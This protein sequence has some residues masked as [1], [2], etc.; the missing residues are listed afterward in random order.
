MELFKLHPFDC[1]NTT[2]QEYFIYNVSGRYVRLASSNL[3]SLS[4][5]HTKS[6][7][8]ILRVFPTGNDLTKTLPILHR[9]RRPLPI[10]PIQ[11]PLRH[12]QRPLLLNLLSNRHSSPISPENQHTMIT[13]YNLGLLHIHTIPP[14]LNLLHIAN[15]LTIPKP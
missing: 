5:Y 4:V 9:Q 15:L 2:T 8:R 6:I 14:G 11:N 7:V 13:P 3:L 1:S 10:P 12:Q